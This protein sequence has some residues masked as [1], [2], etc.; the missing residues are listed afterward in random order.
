MP[1][2]LF[3]PSTVTL[4]TTHGNLFPVR[5]I[6]CIGR[7]YAEHVREM[8][9]DPKSEPPFFFMKPT[10]AVLPVPAG[11][12]GTLPYPS[13]T[14]ELHHELEL[15][16]CLRSGDCDIPVDTALAHVWGYA[17]ALDMTRRDRQAEAKAARRPWELAKSFDASAPM[18]PIV[19][20]ATFGSPDAGALTLAVN[21]TIRQQGDLS[22]MVW[23]VAELIAEL[24]KSSA[25]AAGDV[26]L[27]GTPSGVGPVQP[28][29][30]LV[31]TIRGLPELSLIVA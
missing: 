20:A 28:G 11:T 22:D 8:G 2:L 1:N 16:V 14:D 19:P 21:G 6:Y 4:P 29:D 15:A 17:A 30:R 9:G 27:T 24:S 7:N 10:D 13:L 25:L 3:P 5:R 18:G 12:Q 26:I 31:G 23:S